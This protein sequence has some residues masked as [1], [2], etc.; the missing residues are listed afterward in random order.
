[1]PGDAMQ[2][3]EESKA[4]KQMLW[5]MQSYLPSPSDTRGDG[6]QCG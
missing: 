5:D 4:L 6:C 2:S 1:M 3:E